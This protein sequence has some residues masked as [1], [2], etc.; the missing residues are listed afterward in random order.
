[1]RTKENEWAAAELETIERLVSLAAEHVQGACKNITKEVLF[2]AP[3]WDIR[4]WTPHREAFSGL[5]VALK[6]FGASLTLLR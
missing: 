4:A 3:G 1:L 6:L 2:W 5:A